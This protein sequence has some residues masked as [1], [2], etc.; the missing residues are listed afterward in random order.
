MNM[1]KMVA[2]AGLAPIVLANETVR[3]ASE[4]GEMIISRISLWF[5]MIPLL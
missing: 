3:R 1:P 4:V 2:L 5:S